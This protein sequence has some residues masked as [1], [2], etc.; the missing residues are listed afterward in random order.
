MYV[1]WS[2]TG[3]NGS[4]VVRGTG[5][6]NVCLQSRRASTCNLAPVAIPI[7]FY[8]LARV[9]SIWSSRGR[10]SALRRR[11][12]SVMTFVVI[13]LRGCACEPPCPQSTAQIAS[14]FFRLHGA[15]AS[16]LGF[17][18]E[19]PHLY[20]LYL[21][22]SFGFTPQRSR[23]LDLLSCVCVVCSYRVR[24]RQLGARDRLASSQ[25]GRRTLRFVP[26]SFV[27][28][29]DS[30]PL[31]PLGPLGLHS[32]RGRGALLA[33]GS[34]FFYYYDVVTQRRCFRCWNEFV[35]SED[36]RLLSVSKGPVEY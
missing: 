4:Q 18:R 32:E 27:D 22:R 9:D 36:F 25:P 21:S 6:S 8:R 10:N 30:L 13:V 19:K 17:P 11:A 35:C 5:R 2:C 3:G 24:S 16:F 14:W 34:K 7:P 29:L 12:R 31:F 1:H 20:T 26:L 23:T 33:M 28:P 15:W